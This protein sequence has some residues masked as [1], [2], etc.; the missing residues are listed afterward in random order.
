MSVI[1]VNWVVPAGHVGVVPFVIVIRLC[2][3]DLNTSDLV[4]WVVLPG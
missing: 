2:V 3:I 4:V 1:V